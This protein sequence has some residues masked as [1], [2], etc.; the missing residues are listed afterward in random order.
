MGSFWSLIVAS[1]L[2]VSFIFNVY[3]WF[4]W[5]F[6]G[7]E[8]F[9][10]LWVVGVSGVSSL[11]HTLEKVRKLTVCTFFFLFS[12]Y[13]RRMRAAPLSTRTLTS[14]H[15]APCGQDF[16][17][18]TSLDPHKKYVTLRIS[19]LHLEVERQSCPHSLALAERNTIGPFKTWAV[20]SPVFSLRACQNQPS[21]A[22]QQCQPIMCQ[23]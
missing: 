15:C 7:W 21:A 11:C 13:S 3:Y 20:Q 10:L 17:F 14:A 19:L 22:H 5:N 8:S 12:T 9:V 16:A 2:L 18:Q 1:A 6:N 23:L 4:S